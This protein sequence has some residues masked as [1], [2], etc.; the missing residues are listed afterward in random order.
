MSDH[1]KVRHPRP[2]PIPLA[3]ILVIAGAVA[4]LEP[5]A[6]PLLLA[7]PAILL[8]APKRVELV[9]AVTLAGL[10][11]GLPLGPFIPC[12]L[13]AIIYAITHG[14]RLAAWLSIA[15]LYLG[16]LGLALSSRR[17]F[18][19]FWEEL[20]WAGLALLAGAIAEFIDSRRHRV[21]AYRQLRVEE[22]KRRE[23]QERL[24]IAR[25][26]HDVL[27]HSL[28]LITVRASVALELIDTHPEEVRSALVAIKQASKSGLDEVRTVLHGL[29]EDAPRTPAP[30]L[31]QLD[32]KLV[33]SG[34]PKAV[35]AA[36]GL[37]AYRI[38]QEALT[39]VIRHSKARSA[40][41]QIHQASWALLI[42]VHDAG[43]A[44]GHGDGN[45]SG[46]TGIRERATALG[47]VAEL[48]PDPDGGFTV[49]VALP[50]RGTK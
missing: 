23:E 9:A 39:N 26:L 47:G 5:W 11:L 31:D 7:G 29:R 16:W 48:G 2:W 36:T 49:H 17:P 46:L 25:E 3:I 33:R 27:A 13:V 43:P 32:V 38:V 21:Q 6:Y 1:A 50:L 15:G 34:H 4:H 42:G 12:T 22:R 18:G 28:S 20:R 19:S 37:A 30:D 45:G 10:A 44:V 40:Q 41:V 24:R 14:R 8:L 35:P